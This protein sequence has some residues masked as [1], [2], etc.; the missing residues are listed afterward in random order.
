MKRTVTT[1]VLLVLALSSAPARAQFQPGPLGA[2]AGYR[3]PVS[4]YLNLLRPG[5]PAINYYG[6]VRP[7]LSFQRSLIGLQQQVNAVGA[8]ATADTQG[9]GLVS[10]GHPIVFNN[11]S[12]YYGVPLTGSAGMRT[13]AFPRS[14]APAARPGT[15]GARP[16]T[17][18]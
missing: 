16:T 11:Y 3:P 13:A 7:E 8:Q 15:A 9:L 1:A 12:H 10:T 4:P 14:P 18:R 2:P 17:P 5:D 6:I